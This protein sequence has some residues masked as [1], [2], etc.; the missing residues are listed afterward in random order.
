MIAAQQVRF[1]EALYGENQQIGSFYYAI[2]MCDFVGA[3]LNALEMQPLV[4]Y[5]NGVTGWN[6]SL[7]ELMK[8]GGRA[9]TT[10]HLFNVR[11]GFTSN[12]EV[13]P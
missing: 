13:L 4:D 7:F 6:V 3:P 12:D 2:G 8:L 10:A 5:I 1:G 11:E 9:N